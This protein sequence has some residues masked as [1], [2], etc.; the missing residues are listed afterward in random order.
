MT[1]SS[2]FFRTVSKIVIFSGIIALGSSGCK[3][4]NSDVIPDT[5]VDFTID[6]N[7]PRFT[8]LNVVGN[9]AVVSAAQLGIFSLGYKNHGVLIYRASEEEFYAFDRTCPYEADLS[10]AVSIANAGDVTAE[11]PGCHTEYVLPSYGYPTDNGPGTLPLKLYQA[12]LT[13]SYLHVYHK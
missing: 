4:R 12:N 6:L 10:Q 1:K 8:D 13:G 11:C 9:T 2:G 7:D 5:F 3:T